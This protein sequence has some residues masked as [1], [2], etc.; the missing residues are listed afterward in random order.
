ML[1]TLFLNLF[2][3]TST[4]ISKECLMQTSER[5]FKI[6]KILDSSFIK[7]TNCP[8]NAKNRFIKFISSASGRLN[9]RHL[10]Q[11]FESEYGLSMKFSNQI[12]VVDAKDFIAESLNNKDLVIDSLSSLYG[13]A[14]INLENN[15]TLSVEC[16]NCDRPGDK[17]IKLL[18]NGK[19]VWL[20]GKIKI[21]RKGFMVKTDIAA[22]SE[23]L[24]DSILEQTY[25]VDSGKVALFSD[26]SNLKFYKSR[27]PIRKGSLLKQNDLVLKNLIKYN[28]KV[29]VLIKSD[30]LSLKTKA[31]ARENGKLGDLIRLFNSKTKKV[32]TGKVIDQNKVLVEL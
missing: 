31:I 25:G 30:G 22:F 29:D 11:L 32:L 20:S 21:K 7:S 17:N 8:D 23:N 28:N 10:S 18:I 6:N 9:P 19:T 27:R 1:K 2:L 13:N 15:D 24:D 3:I 12:E 5:V 16:G 14:S 26:V 4:A